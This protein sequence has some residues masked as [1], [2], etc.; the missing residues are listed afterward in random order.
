VDDSWSNNLGREFEGV[1]TDASCVVDVWV[2]DGRQE[3]DIR[4]LEGIPGNGNK[5][6]KS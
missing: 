1:M 3:S 2:V 5:G 4:R 6:S